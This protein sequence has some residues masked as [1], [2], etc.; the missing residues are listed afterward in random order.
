MFLLVNIAR[1]LRELPAV[2]GDEVVLF[3][4]MTAESIHDGITTLFWQ[5]TWIYVKPIA[6]IAAWALRSL[7]SNSAV[8]YM[9]L[10]CMVLKKNSSTMLQVLLGITYIL[11]RRYLS[12]HLHRRFPWS[13]AV[14]DYVHLASPLLV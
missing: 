5:D 11:H 4:A 12:D 2:V 7:M 10:S 9:Q 13:S 1:S 8:Y 6:L 3:R 14:G